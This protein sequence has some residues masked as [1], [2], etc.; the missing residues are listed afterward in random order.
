MFQNNPNKVVQVIL[1]WDSGWYQFK[2]NFLYGS[3][4]LTDC[5]MAA[6]IMV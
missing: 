1:N 3:T 5:T 4:Q 6:E 2:L